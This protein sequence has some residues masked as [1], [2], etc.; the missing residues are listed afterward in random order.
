MIDFNYFLKGDTLESMRY[1]LP[2]LGMVF[3]VIYAM[4]GKHKAPLFRGL[5]A[6][7]LLGSCCLAFVFY[8]APH[9]KSGGYLNG[10]EFFHYYLGAKYAPELDYT[11][12]YLASW[13]AQRDD[14]D[15]HIP[16]MV[17]NLE[18]EGM[19]RPT[20]ETAAPVRE[21][22]TDDRWAMFV[23]D[24]DFL[25]F[26]NM[27]LWDRMHRDKGYNATPAWSLVA[28]PIASMTSTGPEETIRW[29]PWIDVAFVIA[30]MACVAW[31]FGP[32]AML[33]LF[34]F[35]ASH[36]L[37]SHFT[38]KAAFLRLDW[39]MCLV[40]AAAM[41]KKEHFVIAGLLTGYAALMRVFPA[42]FAV[43]VA[44]AWFWELARKGPYRR[45]YF[46][47]FFA[48]AAISVVMCVASLGVFGVDYWREFLA[49]ITGHNDD[50]SAWRVGFKYLFL[51][52][53]ESR[54]PGGIAPFQYLENNQTLYYGCILVGLLVTVI[55][56]R[57]LPPHRALILGFVPVFLL[58]SPTYYYMVM[59]AVPFL[60]FAEEGERVPRAVGLVLMFATSY[61]GHDL[62]L[63]H[64]RGWTTYFYMSLLIGI[65]CAYMLLMGLLTFKAKGE[66]MDTDLTAE[67]V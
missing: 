50:L 16:S 12:L 65:M 10:Y 11:G 32:R 66:K 64:G 53:P 28:M 7:A 23:Q 36:Y 52:A 40:M 67:N 17:R 19:M 24:V 9:W 45:A 47:F 30:A 39:V 13:E 43:G 25:K 14:G 37:M 54:S 48:M 59:L 5:L 35:L 20:P 21:K 34:L 58:V 3:V 62:Y 29:I 55:A 51:W 57:N 22:F 8:T 56:A 44:G 18:T 15:S 61:I 1:L 38:L 31:A 41:L 4:L 2:A 63:E 26:K 42:F 49:K 46:N 60:F 6:A 33:L 27:S